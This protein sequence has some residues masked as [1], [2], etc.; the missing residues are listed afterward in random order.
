MRKIDDIAEC[1]EFLLR[2]MHD[3]MVQR[4]TTFRLDIFSSFLENLTLWGPRRNDGFQKRQ[5]GVRSL[6][7][8]R[9]GFF[10]RWSYFFSNSSDGEK[11]KQNYNKNLTSFEWFNNFGK[12][13]LYRKVYWTRIDGLNAMMDSNEGWLSVKPDHV[14]VKL[15]LFSIRAPRNPGRPPDPLL[16]YLMKTPWTC[17]F[18]H[19]HSTPPHSLSL[20]LSEQTN[21]SRE[22]E[23]SSVHERSPW[24][25]KQRL[26]K[27]YSRFDGKSEGMWYS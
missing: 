25:S 16:Y 13:S 7:F 4:L 21:G 9:V 10:T 8:S 24:P 6:L 27:K 19:F 20:S 18:F 5:L 17:P 15:F 26:Y 14:S 23:K 2:I 12:P 3:L 11:K 1:I 22:F